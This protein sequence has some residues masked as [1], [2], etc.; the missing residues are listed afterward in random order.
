MEDMHTELILRRMTLVCI[1]ITAG[2]SGAAIIGWVLNWLLLARIS[3]AYIPMAPSSALSFVILSFALF[4]YARKPERPQAMTFAKVG[5]FLV[6]LVCFIILID[7]FTG[8]GLDIENLLYFQPEK[9]DAV[10]IG[11]MSPITAANFLL[12]ACALLLLLASPPGKQRAKGAA[13]CLATFVFSIGLVIVVGYLYGTP[14]LYGGTI[15]PVALTTA[16]AFVFMGLGLIAAIGQYYWPISLLAGSS[17]RARLLRAFLPVT[18]ALILIQG[19][20]DI[21][22]FPLVRIHVLTS[23]LMAILSVILF[24][25]I[26]SKIAQVIGGDIDRANAERKLAEE[27]IRRL[28]SIVEFSDDAIFSKTLDGIILSWNPGAEKL[29]GYSAAEASGKPVSILIPP[30]Y[31]DEVPKIL[32]RI[33]HGETITHYEAKRVKKDGKQID[34]SLTISPIKDDAGKIIGASTIARDITERKRVEEEFKRSEEKYRTLV[35]N[36][37]DY[38]MRYDRW[39]RHIFANSRTF[40][41][42]NMTAEEFIGKTHLELGFD[43]HLCD[44]WEKAIDKAFETG[45][46]QVEVFEWEDASGAKMSLEWRVY[47]EYTPDGKIETLLGISRDIT[48]RKRAEEIR[49]ENERLAYANQAKSEFLASMSHDL[50]TPL[51]AIIG[52]SELLKQKTPGELNEKQEHFVDNVLSS[53]KHLLALIDDI[54][55]ISK[56]E[57][58]KIELAIEEISVPSVTDDVL[59]LIKEKAVRHKVILNK[60][61][62]PRLDVIEADKTKFKQ[63]LFNLLDNAVKFS[64]EEGGT[65][66]ITTKKTDDMAEISV[67]DTG[68]GIK[69]EDMGKLFTKFQQLEIG[70]KIGGTGLG[71]AISKQLVELHGGKIRVE[72]RY[73]EGSTFTFLLPLKSKKQED[74]EIESPCR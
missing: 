8:A 64:K 36:I 54:L 6:L 15:I 10:P 25:I 20:L 55:D 74:E 66:T 3:P 27:E 48:E 23:S 57:A 53:S 26:I 1:A 47:P 58:G 51:N 62:D 24:S 45:Q 70:R 61:F 4:V 28:A 67:S 29:Y 42:N 68:V 37:P 72:S 73:G 30:G 2:I 60:E 21:I 33:K 5:A 41:A 18:I 52:F 59:V 44:I 16:F 46:S 71:L 49:L 39:H 63:I 13:V 43:P 14:L 19:W 56:I 69:E 34:V 65:V 12:S 31:F 40:R 9:F 50:R 38:I 22:I 35:E 7:F 17:V 32:E 11:R